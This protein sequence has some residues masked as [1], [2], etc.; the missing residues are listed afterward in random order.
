VT[1]QHL[2]SLIPD[3]ILG[4]KLIRLL[5]DAPKLEN[6]D[7]TP[8]TTQT[9]ALKCQV[10]LRGGGQIG[11]VL[12]PAGEV[13]LMKML[14]VGKDQR[15]PRTPVAVEVYFN[16]DDLLAVVVDVD[17]KPAVKSGLWTPGQPQ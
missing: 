1:E 5:L 16:C 17:M 13:G 4:R 11:G 15:D 10:M 8:D 14:I 6:P 9:P 7:G 2:R 12:A 3:S